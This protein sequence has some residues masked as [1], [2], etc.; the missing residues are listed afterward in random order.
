MLPA[1]PTGQ[2]VDVG[3]VAERV[4]DLERR[5]LLALDARRVDRV[6]QLDR[7]GLGELAGQGQAVVEVAVDLQQRGAVG[8]RLAQLAHRDL[9]L[10]HE[11][12]RTSCRP[13]SRRR[14]REALVLPVEAQMTAL[15][16]VPAATRDRRRHAA[17]LERAGRVEPLE[18]DAD[19]GADDARTG[20]RPGSAACR[21]RRS[22]T[23]GAPVERSAAGRRTRAITP[24]HWW[25]MSRPLPRA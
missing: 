11:H 14:R 13:W 7:V 17:V 6:D 16:P 23:T 18:L 1:L 3:G 5:R 8:D 15:A 24:R 25:A 2:A 10:G 21:P 9:A 12:A 4:D 19:L 22:V 20:A